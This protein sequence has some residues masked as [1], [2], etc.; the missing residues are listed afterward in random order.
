MITF[1]SLTQA[2][3]KIPLDVDE[4]TPVF[5]ESQ[6]NLQEC[7]NFIHHAFVNS[8]DEGEREQ[9]AFILALLSQAK[10]DIE[11]AEKTM[12]QI[13]PSVNDYISVLHS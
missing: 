11:K 1:E 12:E 9:V 2:L 3:R 5:Q 8:D 13:T 6:K 10:N 4:I 7:N